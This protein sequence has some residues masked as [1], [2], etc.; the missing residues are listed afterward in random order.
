[1]LKDRIL[2]AKVALITG[3]ARRIGADIAKT[4]HACGMNIVLH[5]FKSQ[6][7]VKEL[8]ADLNQQR[9]DSAIYLQADL[10]D[11]PR[12]AALV[13]QAAKKW[14][15]LDCLINN[16][17][18]FY[19]T[20]LGKVTEFAWNDLLGS[21]LKA[22]FFL[23]QAAIPYL[24]KDKGCIINLA[25]IHGERPLREYSP[26]CI[27]KAGMIMLTKCLAK[28]LGPEIRVNA[29][30]PGPVLWPEGTNLLNDETKQELIK[31]TSLRRQGDPHEIAKAVRYLVN[32]ADYVTGQIMVVD[33]G[34]SLVI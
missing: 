6:T 23:S 9:A 33:G 7:E 13:D 32:D 21:N 3:S 26:Y 11:T 8:C 2:P 24:K 1:M 28:E 12:L 31:R 20:G 4:L 16:A 14:D 5:Y 27:S 25:D 19:S 29:V 10:N 22:P 30:S 34:R 18:R 17:S 15:R